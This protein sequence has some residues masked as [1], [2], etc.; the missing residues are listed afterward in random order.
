LLSSDFIAFAA[1]AELAPWKSYNVLFIHIQVMTRVY[2]YKC[3]ESV[4]MVSIVTNRGGLSSIRHC[5]YKRCLYKKEK[6][7]RCRD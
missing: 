6:E 5:V 1:A 7:K 2:T 3:G 4:R